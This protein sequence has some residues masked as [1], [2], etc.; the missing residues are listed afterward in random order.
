M[1][2]SMQDVVP[3]DYL[4]RLSVSASSAVAVARAAALLVLAR[5]RDGNTVL[6]LVDPVSLGVGTHMQP[7]LLFN[8]L[9]WDADTVCRC[10]RVVAV[11]VTAILR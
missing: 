9:A 8:S 4:S 1:W 6:E 5:D 2:H 11:G 7:V 3:A 10:G